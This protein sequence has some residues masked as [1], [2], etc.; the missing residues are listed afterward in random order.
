MNEREI[1]ELLT[2]RHRRDATDLVCG[3]GDDCAVIK[4]NGSSSWVVTMD[5]LIESV[6]F[7]LRW[8]DPYNLGRKSVSVNVSDIGAMGADPSFLLLSLGLPAEY[9]NR[10]LEGISQGM[11]DACSEYD[12]LLVGGDTVR[13]PSGLVITI[14]A[15]GEVCSDDIVFRKGAK[16]NDSIWVS[17]LLGSAAAGLYLC[18]M[19]KKEEIVYRE[20]V[21]AHLNPHPRLQLGIELARKHLVHSMM[22]LSDGLATDLAHLCRQSSTGAVIDPEI[23]PCS[24]SLSQVAE[25][26]DMHPDR[27]MMSGGED[28]ELLFTASGDLE[29]AIK[30]LA[31][32]MGIRITRI[33]RIDTGQGVRMLCRSPGKSELTEQDISYQGFDHF[34]SSSS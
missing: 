8:H 16:N 30:A 15:I 24:S 9:D 28:Y 23:L 12:C 34:T 27:L 22:D 33:G 14:T 11:A 32:D 6:H 1:I 31:Q 2:R 5:T 25:T 7:D 21:E 4:K 19:G 18:S 3:V 26:L 20:F 10:L 17:G 13:S 29:D